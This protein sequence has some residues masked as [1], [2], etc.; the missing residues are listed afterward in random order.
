MNKQM[1]KNLLKNLKESI[2]FI[3]FQSRQNAK[4]A[5]ILGSGL[6][7]YADNLKIKSII[8]TS[9]IPHY[10]QS[11]VEGHKGK[12]IFGELKNKS[13]L[14]FQGRVHYYETGTLNTIL[15]PILVA[16]ALGIETLIATNA[17]GGVNRQFHPGDLML[18][19]DHVNLTFLNPLKLVTTTTKI[20]CDQVYD[21]DLN[22]LIVKTSGSLNIP[23]R[24]GVYVCVKGP[25]YETASEVEMVRRIGGDAVGMSTVNETTLAHALGMKVAGISCI[26]NY[27]TGVTSAKLHH[28]EV[29]QV[30]NMVKHRFSDLITSILLNVR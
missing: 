18:I 25:S 9:T 13:I 23:L 14:V 5:L 11:T 10:P 17:A 30:A 19:K 27:A 15:Y 8:D 20:S 3:K 24:E 28:S 2:R 21:S 4:I 16:H 12:V 7:D 29:T 26:T 22:N 1:E 6:G